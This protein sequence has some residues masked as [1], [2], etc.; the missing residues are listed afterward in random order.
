MAI[1]AIRSWRRL[2]CMAL[3]YMAIV[4]AEAAEETT[5]P[6]GGNSRGSSYWVS[7][8]LIVS[9]VFIMLVL[10]AV[11]HSDDDLRKA[12][13]QTVSSTISIFGAVLFFQACQGFL[14][15]AFS[16]PEEEVTFKVFVVY[17]VQGEFWFVAS[18]LILFLVSVGYVISESGVRELCCMVN[19]KDEVVKKMK[20]ATSDLLNA[21]HTYQV[22]LK[23]KALEDKALEV[24]G[25]CPF[26]KV[27]CNQKCWGV[28]TGHIAGFAAVSAF[29]AAQQ[30][31][32]AAC[33]QQYASLVGFLAVLVAGALMHSHFYLAQM[34]RARA[35]HWL[36]M[37]TPSEL[38]NAQLEK[39]RETREQLF[40][41]WNDVAEESENDVMGVMLG[42]L[43]MNAARSAILSL[44]GHPVRFPNIE[45]ELDAREDC[46]PFLLILLGTAIPVVRLLRGRALLPKRYVEF[47][48][49]FAQMFFAWCFF[50]GTQ[51]IFHGYLPHAEAISSVV[52]AFNQSL[53]SMVLIFLLDKVADNSSTANAKFLRNFIAAFGVL[54][55][56]AWERAFDATLGDVVKENGLQYGPGATAVLRIVAAVAAVGLVLPA[57]RLFILPE[58]VA[59]EIQEEKEENEEEEKEEESKEARAGHEK[60]DDGVYVKC[61]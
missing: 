6:G 1:L 53:L 46:N 21:D 55:G 25:A 24:T 40:D 4:Q 12:G 52:S 50:F 9:V 48:K 36:A 57:W 42:F 29:G 3:L 35:Q 2:A 33:P 16:L 10:Y 47:G 51:S 56:F 15:Y 31:A 19:H 43:L 23:A 7:I 30:I 11:N 54:I 18:Q 37:P 45:G 39:I 61:P 8:V 38:P 20:D 13:K 22:V 60:Q 5:A 28:L 26:W 14:Q 17:F 32:V 44:G 41:M 59:I 27:T 49:V 34:I 58:V